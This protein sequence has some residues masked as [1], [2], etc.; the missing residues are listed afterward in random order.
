LGSEK[1]IED[2]K[3]LYKL[4]KDYLDIDLLDDF[5]QKLK[6]KELFKRYLS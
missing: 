1:D 5:N 6:T 4:F 3:H 2:A